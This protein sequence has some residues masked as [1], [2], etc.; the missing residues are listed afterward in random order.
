MHYAMPPA[1]AAAECVR[2]VVDY[3]TFADSPPGPNTHCTS[4]GY[5]ALAA[6][7]LAKR[8]KDLGAT[9]PRYQGNFLC[10]IDGYPQNGCGNDSSVPYWSFWFWAHGKWTYSQYGVDSYTVADSDRDGHPDPIGFRYQAQGAAVSPRANPGYP[11]PATRP[12]T[13]APVAP[14]ASRAP[15]PA[16]DP[17]RSTDPATSAPG[18]TGSATPVATRPVGRTPRAT[19]TGAPPSDPETT[20]PGIAP[21]W[22]AREFPVGTVGGGVLAL[23]LLG[24]TGWQFRRAANR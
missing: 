21:V 23:V 22:S 24:A 9:P 14:P 1:A 15:A 16:A 11:A 3:G 13:T 5:G 10:G 6:D 4:V 7:A 8:A 12:P 18:P 20:P 2:V 17:A 19:T